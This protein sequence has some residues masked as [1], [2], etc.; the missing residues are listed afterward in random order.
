MIIKKVGII[1][2][3]FVGQA[4]KKEFSQYYP[5]NTYDKFLTDLSSHSSIAE[6][7]ESSDAVFVCVPTPMR[8]DGS[9]DISIV[10]EVC[11]QASAA[12]D[13]HFV[14]IKSTITP[15]T[16]TYLNNKFNTNKIVFNPEFLTERF[17]AR[18]FKN[19][20]RVILGG[21]ISATTSLKQFYSHVFPN[22]KVIKTESTVAEYV[23]YLSNCFLAVKV[24]VANEFAKL[25][26]ASG[27]DYDKIAEYANFDPR[28]GDTHWVVPGPDG[29]KG[30]GGTCFPKDVSSL[31]HQMLDTGM[32]SYIL[33]AARNRNND[34][35][36]KE[37]D[38]E[39]NKGRA[40]VE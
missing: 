20:N 2:Q 23:K 15:G 40:V 29:K 6:L 17:A 1:G 19:T 36:R 10:E 12:G 8:E 18:D 33:N 24:S 31:L 3:G 26:E 32:M 16:T 14:V 5:I 34:L 13:D 39:H 35:D 21:D 9:C 37:K 7:C 22:V 27:V 38:W 30:F 28:L 11:S 4:L 25:C